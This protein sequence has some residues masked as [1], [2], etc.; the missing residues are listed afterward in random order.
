MSSNPLPYRAALL[1]I[2][3][4]LLTPV[5]AN[6]QVTITVQDVTADPGESNV[7]LD[8]HMDNQSDVCGVQFDLLY[9]TQWVTPGLGNLGIQAT[10]SS[11]HLSSSFV[12]DPNAPTVVIGTRIIAFSFGLVPISP[13]AGSLANVVISI[14]SN[15]LNP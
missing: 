2:I 15:A 5:G 7:L 11:W 9:P 12:Y 6:A 13:G 10:N 4:L 8:I 3:V 14:F 1:S